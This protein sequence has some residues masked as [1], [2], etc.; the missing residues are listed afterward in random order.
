MF[1]TQS[2]FKTRSGFKSV[3]GFQ[4]RS[5]DA[6]PPVD[7]VTFRFPL[8]G[9]AGDTKS[10]DVFTQARASAQTEIFNNN[11][12]TYQANEPAFSDYGIT[13]RRT[14][15][16]RHGY[17][18]DVTQLQPT[19]AFTPDWNYGVGQSSGGVTTFYDG[20]K[21]TVLQDSSTGEHKIAMAK[22]IGLDLDA[23]GQTFVVM[24]ELKPVGG[25]KFVM[26]MTNLND[27][28]IVN[29][30]D[31]TFTGAVLGGYTQLLDEGKV[32]IYHVA[33]ITGNNAPQAERI[34]LLDDNENVSFTGDPTKGVEITSA[35]YANRRRPNQ[36]CPIVNNTGADLTMIDTTNVTASL[37]KVTTDRDF[38]FYCEITNTLFPTIANNEILPLL[39]YHNIPLTAGWSLSLSRSN[40]GQLLFLVSTAT[41]Q[42]QKIIN[43][44]PVLETRRVS[45]Q[46]LDGLPAVLDIDEAIGDGLQQPIT[47][48]PQNLSAISYSYI[49]AENPFFAVREV[50]RIEKTG[51]TLTQAQNEQ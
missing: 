50:K 41:E 33:D 16:N 34:F 23:S 7:D 36:Y 12:V 49:L 3:K 1:K 24:I 42:T 37:S 46:V 31:G 13:T 20:V 51:L 4:S 6:P 17:S 8:L 27:E 38:T 9:D 19:G 2:G 21:G 30:E 47:S 22:V 26:L 40:T 45:F 25:Q 43:E 32:F 28:I 29:L 35:A 15:T 48:Y 39:V 10:S 14:D 44:W 18:A 5:G 11:L